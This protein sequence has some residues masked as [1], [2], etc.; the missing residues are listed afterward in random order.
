[1]GGILISY[2]ELLILKPSELCDD[3]FLPVER[4]EGFLVFVFFQ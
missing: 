2:P 4:C 3:L 1:M